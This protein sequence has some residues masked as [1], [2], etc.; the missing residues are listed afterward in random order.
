[1]DYLEAWRS[2]P[3]PAEIPYP[4]VG[5]GPDGQVLYC[6][7]KGRHHLELEIFPTP[8]TPAEF[9]Y[10]DRAGDEKWVEDYNVGDFLSPLVIDKF[11]IFV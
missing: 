10:M 7:D 6:W 5:I 11:M 4:S 3:K 8:G 1:M 2:I 9:F